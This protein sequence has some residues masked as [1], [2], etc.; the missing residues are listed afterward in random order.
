MSTAYVDTSAIV[1]VAV[2]E[3]AGP[4]VAERLV[5]FSRRFSSNLLEAELRATLIRDGYRYDADLV[6]GITWVLPER[7]LA[8]EISEVLDAGYLRGAD[9]WHV[10]AALHIADEP[11]RLT[12]VTLDRRQAEVAAALGFQT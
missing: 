10:A 8:A 9:L 12:F 5:T 7:P 1:A 4:A 3:P 2:D 6:S 11:E